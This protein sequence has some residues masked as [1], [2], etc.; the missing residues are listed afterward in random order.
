MQ[1]KEAWKG[2]KRPY[3]KDEKG[4]VREFYESG[5]GN[6]YVRRENRLG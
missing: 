1:L 4:V 2:Y 3:A 5:V 6:Q